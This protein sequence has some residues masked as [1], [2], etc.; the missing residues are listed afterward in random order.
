VRH[1]TPPWS[2][3]GELFGAADATDFCVRELEHTIDELGA[4]RIAAFIGEPV[5]G[6]A[7]MVTPPGDYWP[8]M[9]P[10]LRRHGILLIADEVIC[11]YGRTGRW[12]A[13]ERYGIAPDLMVTAKGLTS[14]YQPLGAVLVSGAVAKCLDRGHDGFPIG[15]TYTGHPTACAVALANLDLLEHEGLVAAAEARGQRFL[16]EL[17]PLAELPYVVEVRGAGLMLG[18]ELARDTP[19]GEEIGARI[20]TAVRDRHGVIIRAHG[21]VLSISPP[22]SLSDE[23]LERIVGAVL[24]EVGG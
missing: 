20:A 18:I 17:A 6:V 7:G 12:F 13:A 11:G 15:Y 22:L 10:I 19:E 3:R 9:A 2:C 21:S 5:M 23:E 8:R 4:E 14:G 24:T 16:R 1:L